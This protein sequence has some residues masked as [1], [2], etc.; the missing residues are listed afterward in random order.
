MRSRDRNGRAISPSYRGVERHRSF[1]NHELGGLMFGTLLESRARRH[2]RTGGAALSIAAHVAIIGVATA[3]T[4]A[5]HRGAAHS[6]KAGVCRIHAVAGAEAD[7]TPR[8]DVSPHIIAHGD[9]GAHHTGDLSAD[10]GAAVAS[11]D[12][13]V[14]WATAGGRLDRRASVGARWWRAW[15]H[16]RTHRRQRGERQMDCP[17][18]SDEHRVVRQAAVSGNTPSERH[19]RTRARPVHGGHDW[20]RRHGERSCDA[21]DA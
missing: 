4:S 2:R 14:E 11:R 1:I 21:V 7:R 9:A 10:D 8:D 16:F 5:G 3:A 18:G 19:R 6:R 17:R 20:P 15:P 12:Q 13:P